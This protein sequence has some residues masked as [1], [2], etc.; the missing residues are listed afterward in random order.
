M[1]RTIIIL[2]TMVFATSVYAQ[3]QTDTSAQLEQLLRDEEPQP[4]PEDEK[5]EKPA[6]VESEKMVNPKELSDLGRLAPFSDVAVI[7]KRYLPKTNRF[8]FY[9]AIGNVL[10]D[11]F[12]LN[13]ILSGRLSFSFT[14]KYAVEAVAFGSSK[15]ERD[16]VRDLRSRGVLTEGFVFPQS[17]YGLDFKWSPIYGKMGFFNNS[18]IPFDQYFLIGGGVTNTNQKTSPTTFHLGTGQIYALSKWM[19]ARWDV[20]CY[21]YS[22]K[23][24]VGT[25]G[26]GN[27]MN[28]HLTLGLSFFFPGAT[29]R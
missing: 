5:P 7:Q 10:N 23:S 25:G 8:E 18:I 11:V 4:T 28:I 16:V 6:V 27:Y 2:M 12:F 17:Y 3:D 1:Q 13:P 20:S 22:S 14:E 19:A 21:W 29:Y 9:P 15:A 26:E 24:T